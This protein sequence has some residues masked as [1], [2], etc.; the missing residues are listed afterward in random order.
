MKVHPY[1][2][3][4]EHREP[5]G[6]LAQPVVRSSTGA[7]PSAEALRAAGVGESREHFFY[8]RCG[9]PN[10]RAFEAAV[11][12]LEGADGAVAFASG[13]AAV[14]AVCF[15]FL[16]AGA[17]VLVADEIYGGTVA[18]A[19]QDLPRFGVRVD[20]FSALDLA[21]LDRA[22]AEPADL[23]V[24]ETP[25]NPTLRIVDVRAVADRCRR[26]NVRTVLDGTFA[27]PP[28]QRALALG[29]DLVL[30]SATKY[31]GG[32]SDVLAGVVAGAHAQLGP[33]AAF[34][35]R[36][37]PVLAPDAAWL[38]CRS[39]ATLSVRLQAQQATAL[40]VARGLQAEMARGRVASVS[41]PGLPDHPDRALV[42]AQMQ[43]G[44]TML[45]FAVPGGLE[46]GR[47]VFDRLRHFARAASLGGV[48]SLATLPA[49]T[50]HASLSPAELA[51]AGIA[52]GLIR[53]SIGLEDAAVLLADLQQALSG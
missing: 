14:T 8:Q 2:T 22:L 35:Q 49:F 7:M 41:Y 50:S 5:Y 33:L 43:G 25:V 20:R 4:A 15:T 23:L 36:T 12:A 9:H 19:G 37:G 28:V 30:H 45:S 40:A 42:A 1:G 51:R 13:M 17:R 18:L 34:R 44:G 24:F 32:H 26:A 47:R 53:L 38:L 46:R 31:F 11:A 52:A 39:M 29:V 16:R 10:E 21:S 48:E 27:P 6:P 3:P